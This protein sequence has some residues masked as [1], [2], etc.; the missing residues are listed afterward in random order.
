[1]KR[2]DEEFKAEVF[3][4]FDKYKKARR[5]RHE[6]LARTARYSA[7]CFSLMIIA[8]GTVFLLR[9]SKNTP[10]NPPD[11]TSDSQKHYGPPGT[12]EI[13]TGTA[14]TETPETAHPTVTTATDAEITYPLYPTSVDEPFAHHEMLDALAA[15]LAGAG[16]LPGMD[17]SDMEAFISSLMVGGRSLFE[18]A[19]A[20]VGCG[21]NGSTMTADW[22]DGSRRASYTARYCASDSGK[23]TWNARFSTNTDL[24]GLPLP[25][26]VRWGDSL[27]RVI[28]VLTGGSTP[29]DLEL[30]CNGKDSKII[31]MRNV[32]RLIL[33][34]P[35]PDAVQLVY[36]ISYKKYNFNTGISSNEL[37]TLT[38]TFTRDKLD[39]FSFNTEKEQF[40]RSGG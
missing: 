21:E 23:A 35:A 20:A 24:A 26:G 40:R 19:P 28:S 3:R 25:A 10:V 22:Q 38:L 16:I 31:T 12:Y 7:L 29:A 27:E 32:E 1:M 18:L 4:R 8:A 6:R 9:G 17:L 5:Q 14:A 15:P 33:K 39:G 30:S 36:T 11:R 37:R 2:T 13:T 34:S